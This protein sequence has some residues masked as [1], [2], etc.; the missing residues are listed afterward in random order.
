ML[1]RI[2]IT[3]LSK[4]DVLL[5]PNTAIKIVGKRK[6]IEYMDGDIRRSRNV[7]LGI[8]TDTDTEVL[9]GVQPGMVV[10]AGQN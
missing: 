8:Q 1:A 10:I 2:Q 3:L 4:P 6:F 9:S 7:E 5:V